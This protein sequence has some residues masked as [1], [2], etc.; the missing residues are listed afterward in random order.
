MIQQR[1]VIRPDAPPFSVAAPDGGGGGDG[2]DGR[3]SVVSLF[4]LSV[5]YQRASLHHFITPAPLLVI[6]PKPGGWRWKTGGRGGG[7]NGGEGRA[8][9]AARGKYGRHLISMVQK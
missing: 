4:A 2:G 7:C 6:R 3:F 9:R 5:D 8:A 1:R